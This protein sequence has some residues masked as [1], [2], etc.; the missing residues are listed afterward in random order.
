M[1][2]A[3]VHPGAAA[4]RPCPPV[5]PLLGPDDVHVWRVSLDR[6]PADVERLARTLATGEIARAKRYRFKADRERFVAARGALRTLLGWYLGIEP[7]QVAFRHDPHGKPALDAAAAPSGLRFNLSHSCGLALIAIA[8]GREVGIDV[9]HVRPD[10][11]DESLLEPADA[12][13]LRALPPEARP[14][15]FVT[16]W[17]RKEALAKATG[18]GLPGA[19]GGGAPPV[20][21]WGLWPLSADP[22]CEAALCVEGGGWRLTCWQWP[23][24]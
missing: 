10:L 14:R 18:L 17:T 11:A 2:D 7:G 19:A 4:W 12:A 3:V 5:A 23:D 9:E 15:A 20:T 16:W 13:A 1:R 21:G 6:G 22:G 8:R 24:P